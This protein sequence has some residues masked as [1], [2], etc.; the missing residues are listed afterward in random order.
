MNVP[1]LPFGLMARAWRWC[2]DLIQAPDRLRT[3]EARTAGADDPRPICQA[4][5]VGRVSTEAPLTISGSLVTW[6]ACNGCGV[7]WEL[8]N[9]GKAIYGRLNRNPPPSPR[10]SRSS[11]SFYG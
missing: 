10:R 7:E 9:F 3:L 6:G 1:S 2:S 11:G 5:G 8:R 4:C